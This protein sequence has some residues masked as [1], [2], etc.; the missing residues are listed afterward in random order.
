MTK[1][2]AEQFFERHNWKRD[3]WGHFHKIQ[4]HYRAT[5]TSHSVKIEVKA[6]TAGWV[7]IRSG[8]L[9]DI[10]LTPDDKL[11]GLSVRGCIGQIPRS[12]AVGVLQ[13]QSSLATHH[14]APLARSRL[15]G[16]E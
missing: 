2:Q 7:R 6:G 15:P 14:E 9:R 1:E 12:E 5:V 8:Y 13:R 4:P 10:T 11:S 3:Q 16:A